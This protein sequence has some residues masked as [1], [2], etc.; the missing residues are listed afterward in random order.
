MSRGIKKL[1]DPDNL[2]N[3]GKIFPTGRGVNGF[4]ADLPTLEGAT[5][6]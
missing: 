6:G 3:P 5:P 4:L 2:L 1:F